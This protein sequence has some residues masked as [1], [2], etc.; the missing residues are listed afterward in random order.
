MNIIY[1]SSNMPPPPALTP[2]LFVTGDSVIQSATAEHRTTFSRS[3]LACLKETG[4]AAKKWCI[5]EWYNR[6]LILPY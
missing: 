4:E 2:L 1:S 3:K 6:P 5:N